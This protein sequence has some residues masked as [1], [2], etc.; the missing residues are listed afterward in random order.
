ML[1]K[2]TADQITLAKS[3]IGSAET[4]VVTAHKNPDGDAVGS[5]LAMHLFLKSIGKNVFT[6]L[7][8]AVPDFLQWLPGYKEIIIHELETEKAKSTIA[9]ADLIFS[10]DYNSLSRVGAEMQKDL[11]SAKA[12]FILID[13][14]QQPGNFAKVIFSDTSACSTCEMIYHFIADCYGES[15]I[16]V[17]MSECIYCGIMTDSGSFRYHSVSQ[18]THNIV[19]NLIAKGLDH[20]QV[21]R[22]VYDT[23]LLDRLKL[24]GYALSEKLQIISDCDTAFIWLSQEELLKNNYRQGDTEGLVNQ[25]LS[26]KGV[27]LAAFFRGGGNEIKISFRSKVSFDV[28]RFAREHWTG[29]GHMNAAGA[30]SPLSM[31]DTLEK[32]KTLVHQLKEEIKNS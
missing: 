5:V 31:E 16:D 28:N 19:G 17:P 15:H 11:E 22:E 25:A 3:L 27:K 2:L 20:A 26:V 9:S 29:G 7:P 23:N 18:D 8:D 13:H 4:I 21:H 30:S 32:F 10:L 12:D 24:I 6:I 1:L 14:H